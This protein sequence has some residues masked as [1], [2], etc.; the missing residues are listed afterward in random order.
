MI[1]VG[2]VPIATL[3]ASV[4]TREIVHN[5]FFGDVE[6]TFFEETLQTIHT[7]VFGVG[8]VIASDF[9]IGE[10][11]FLDYPCNLPLGESFTLK[12]IVVGVIYLYISV[13]RN[14]FCSELIG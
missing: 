3:E 2:F 8:R 1:A 12:A 5:S 10:M 11:H 7:D 9:H 6:A 13:R 4:P 14:K